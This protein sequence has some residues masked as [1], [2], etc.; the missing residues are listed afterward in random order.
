MTASSDKSVIARIHGRVQGVWF[1]AWTVEN[2]VRRGLRGWVRNRGDGSVEALF[3]GPAAAVDEM[4]EA[5][6]RGPRSARVERID[7]TLADPVQE[8][9]FHQR[10]TA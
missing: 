8:P 10:P 4:I 3:C 5:C 7:Q 2:A 1:R 9:G 6:R